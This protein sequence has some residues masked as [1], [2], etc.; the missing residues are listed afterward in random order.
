M[1]SPNGK[2]EPLHY[3]IDYPDRYEILIDVPLADESTLTIGLY[4]RVLKVR[5]KL[6][7]RLVIEEHE[8]REYVKRI[9]VPEDAEEEYEV[10]VV[11]TEG[12]I[13]VVTFPKIGRP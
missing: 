13:I 9:I 1:I 10:E 7:E 2:M 11:K 4:K 8:V 6:R 12:P 5:V 3:V